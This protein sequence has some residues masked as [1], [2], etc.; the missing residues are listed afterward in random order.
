MDN[1]VVTDAADKE[2]FPAAEFVTQIQDHFDKSNTA[3]WQQAYYVNAT[4]WRGAARGAP[5]FLCVGG[6]GPAL[7]GSAVV[8]SVHCN[9]AVE[10]LKETGALMFALEH[11]YYGCHNISACPVQDFKDVKAALRFLSSRQ[12]VEDVA[13]F[14][15]SMS[16]KYKLTS[17]NKWITWGGSYPGMVAGWSRLKHPELIHA[18]VASSAPVHAK[19]DMYEYNDV[20]SKAYTVS[21]NGVGGSQECRDAIAAGHQKIKDM[22]ETAEGVADVEKLLGLSAGTLQSHEARVEF[23]GNGVADFPAQSNEPSCSSP[24]CNIRKICEIMTNS[25]LGE[26]LQRLTALRSAQ[27]S[28]S[29]GKPS[30]RRQA[31]AAA[32][33]WPDFWLYQTCTEFGFYQTCSVNSSCMYVKGLVDVEA[34][35]SGCQQFGIA[36]PDISKN[37]ATT[38]AHYGALQPTGPSDKLGSCVLWPNGEVDPWSA[39]SVLQSPGESQPVLWVPGASHHAWTHPSSSTDQASVVSARQTIKEQ[40]K[41]FLSSDCTESRAQETTVYIV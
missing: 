5:I 11:R 40:V 37:I 2:K 31:A 13:T 33:G 24:A 21:D 6:E 20:V 41:K 25:S 30:S 9:L 34:E 19:L 3:T 8:S 32:P 4:Y 15:R 36:I 29:R 26:P 17:A 16:D 39:L 12:A 27:R 38:N 1:I 14:V 22:I 7:D 23:L 18:S 28:S 35:A 10:W